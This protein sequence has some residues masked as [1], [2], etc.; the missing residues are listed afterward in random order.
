M[1]TPE[2]TQMPTQMPTTPMP[3]QIPS[4]LPTNSP[5]Q[6]PTLFGT[7]TTV[8]EPF[9]DKIENF[10]WVD[11]GIGASCRGGINESWPGGRKCESPYLICLPKEN[12]PAGTF[13]N[14]TYFN[15]THRYSVKECQRECR[16]DQRCR[17]F[18]FVA[19]A[20]SNRGDCILI[21]D[22]DI[23]VVDR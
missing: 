3:T 21:D 8:C 5:T 23:V 18:E 19:D 12:T 20:D 17:G 1:P 14:R 9:S 10:R 2:P 13:L 11:R 7:I 16:F 15:D 4:E 22:V 6:T